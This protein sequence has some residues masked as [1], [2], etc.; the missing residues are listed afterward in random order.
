MTRGNKLTF[1]GWTYLFTTIKDF[2]KYG[3]RGYLIQHRDNRP[4]GIDRKWTHILEGK[5]KTPTESPVSCWAPVHPLPSFW[6]VKLRRKDRV[7]ERVMEVDCGTQREEETPPVVTKLHLRLACQHWETEVFNTGPERQGLPTP[8]WKLGRENAATEVELPLV[9]WF[10]L[11]APRPL[12]LTELFSICIS[13][14]P[15]P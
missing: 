13:V 14:H 3:I 10:W 11:T 12:C 1:V 4:K 15:S 9:S 8:L 2:I 5:M 6:K 7:T